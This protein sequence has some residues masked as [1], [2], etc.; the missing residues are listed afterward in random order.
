MPSSGTTRSDTAAGQRFGRFV[1]QQSLGKGGSGEVYLAYD[2]VKERSVALKRLERSL[3][4]SDEFRQ[5]LQREADRVSRLNND[6]IT[7][8]YECLDVDGEVVLVMEYVDGTNLRER[9]HDGLSV[10]ES[11]AV[12]IDCTAALAAAH[13]LGI[14]HHDIKPENIMLTRDPQGVK[15]CDFGVAR[16]LPDFL[17]DVNAEQLAGGT[18]PYMAPEV[19][20]D[21]SPDGRADLYSVGVVLYEALTGRLPFDA[22]ER[23]ELQRLI[24]EEDP[25]P[26]RRLNLQVPEPLERIVLRLLAKEPG[27][28][29]S[30]AA[31][32]RQ[33]LLDERTRLRRPTERYSPT[34]PPLAP[35]IPWSTWLVTA[36]VIVVLLATVPKQPA[37]MALP[38]TRSLAV[39]SFKAIGGDPTHRA[40]CDGLIQGLTSR[41][42]TA[43][44]GSG[45]QVAPAAE[46]QGRHVET[47]SQA[48]TLLGATMSLEGVCERRGS[49]VRVTSL[50]V[51][52]HTGQQ[53]RVASSIEPAALAL[54][55]QDR[56][57]ADSVRMLD[58]KTVPRAATSISTA[59]PPPGAY[60]EYLVGRGLLLDYGKPDN[61][62]KAIDAFSRAL[63]IDRRFAAAQA[64]LG[65]AYSFLYEQTK[66]PKQ[67]EQAREACS[68]AAEL[69]QA[70]A[71][72]HTCLGNVNNRTGRYEEAVAEFQLAQRIEPTNDEAYRGVAFALEKLGRFGEAERIYRQAI[73]LRPDYWAGYSWLATFFYARGQY[74][75]A[76]EQFSYAIALSPD[77]VRMYRNRGGIYIFMGRYEEAIADLQKA[78]TLQPTKSGYTNLGQVYYALREFDNAVAMFEQAWSL[79]PRDFTAASNLASGYAASGAKDKALESYRRAATLADD[80]LKAD[81]RNGSVL[82]RLASLDAGLGDREKATEHVRRGIALRPDDNECAFWAG[83]TFALL[84]QHDRALE[85][86]EKAVSLG[87][88]I[89]LI[90]TAVELDL[91]HG[92]LRFDALTTTQ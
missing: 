92:D 61:I 81:P 38:V 71:S 37:A 62:A 79:G 43:A 17:R 63:T 76:A 86:L 56:V 75:E 42:T 45:L 49:D 7:H 22:A 83:V 35:P 15:V 55:L 64:G 18:I 66:Q 41:L 84:G 59:P 6:H 91:L 44:I 47:R 14:V 88:S 53:L 74:R 68:A 46:V 65:E 3:R 27:R 28:R 82:V 54:T 87:Y 51:D 9:L 4:F 26:P 13:T 40:Y 33:V 60:T 5:R 11:L 24:L 67:L 30:S 90:R 36:G 52:T 57:F 21:R 29:Y 12:V 19:L 85:W 2:T 48:R 1:L 58:L 20:L 34:I 78:N 89:A 77:N 16:R 73:E 23:T 70:L 32:L 25:V 72:A 50:L 10:D 80:E 69:D 39:L 31:D 8:V